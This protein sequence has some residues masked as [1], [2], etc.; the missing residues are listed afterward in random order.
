MNEIKRFWPINFSFGAQI[1]DLYFFLLLFFFD[2][3]GAANLVDDCYP[4]VVTP[5]IH[6]HYILLSFRLSVYDS[7]SLRKTNFA[8]TFL[9][10]VFDL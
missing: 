9:T 2:P 5:S 3:R 6:V 10:V 4:S 7:D 1:W 8:K